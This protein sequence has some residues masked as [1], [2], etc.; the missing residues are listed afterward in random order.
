MFYMVLTIAMLV[1]IASD[2]RAIGGGLVT[3][4]RLDLSRK[5]GSGTTLAIVRPVAQ[6]QSGF[7]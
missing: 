7:G 1:I 3:V 5:G 2:I 6:P 4:S